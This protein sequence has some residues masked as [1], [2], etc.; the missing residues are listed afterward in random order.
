MVGVCAAYY[1]ASQVGL[2]L[3]IPP[4]TTSVMWP[5][6]IILTMALMLTPTRRWAWCLAAALS[7]HFAVQGGTGW[8]PLLIVAFFATNSLEAIAGAGAFR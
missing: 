4:A 6:N 8:P 5:P 3:R 2:A 7:A 1:I